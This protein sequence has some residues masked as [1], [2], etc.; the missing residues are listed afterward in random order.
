M[1]EGAISTHLL[2]LVEPCSEAA[3]Y[4]HALSLVLDLQSRVWPPLLEVGSSN[5]RRELPDSRGVLQAQLS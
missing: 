5:G 1:L 2:L 4:L 3:A